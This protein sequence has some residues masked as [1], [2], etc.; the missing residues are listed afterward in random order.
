MQSIIIV[1]LKNLLSRK[2]TDFINSVLVIYIVDANTTCYASN[3]VRFETAQFFYRQ[4]K[5]IKREQL[6]QQVRNC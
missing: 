5:Y 2:S 6:T 3:I 4:K 1:K